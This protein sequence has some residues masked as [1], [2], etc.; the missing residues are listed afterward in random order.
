MGWDSRLGGQMRGVKARQARHSNHGVIWLGWFR[1]MVECTTFRYDP[2]WHGAGAW[3]YPLRRVMSGV[4]GVRASYGMFIYGRLGWFR[5]G[6]TV[7]VTTVSVRFA[8]AW[9]YSAGD[10]GKLTL[11]KCGGIYGP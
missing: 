8:T 6:S 7:L 5:F 1:L 4:S 11:E 2:S 10:V 9:H 3:C